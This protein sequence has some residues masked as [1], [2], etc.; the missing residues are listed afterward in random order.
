MKEGNDISNIVSVKTVGKNFIEMAILN[1][2]FTPISM[3]R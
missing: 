1:T 2:D 3:Q